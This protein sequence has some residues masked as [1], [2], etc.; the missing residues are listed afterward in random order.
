MCIGIRWGW[1]IVNAMGAT[2]MEIEMHWDG[3][4]EIF[5]GHMDGQ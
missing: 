5:W 1:G 2:G 3:N 4:K